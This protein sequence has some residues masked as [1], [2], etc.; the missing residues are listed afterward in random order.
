MTNSFNVSPS[1]VLTTRVVITENCL[2]G[3]PS[4]YVNVPNNEIIQHITIER[5]SYQ[6]VFALLYFASVVP[7]VVLG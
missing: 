5:A 4:G 7:G 3:V 2:I 6:F 1:E